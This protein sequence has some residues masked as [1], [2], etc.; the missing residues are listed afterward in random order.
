MDGGQP[1]IRP[2]PC[3]RCNGA[4][5]P[6]RDEWG[7][8][9]DVCLACGAREYPGQRMPLTLEEER[10]LMKLASIGRGERVRPARPSEPRKLAKAAAQMRLMEA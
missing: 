5:I 2:T 10:A 3:R 4:V 1:V 8:R 6:E 9:E 7:Q